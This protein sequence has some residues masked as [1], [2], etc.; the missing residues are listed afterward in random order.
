MG[1]RNFSTT[2]VPLPRKGLTK[3]TNFV[4]ERPRFRQAFT[5]LELQA[6]IHTPSESGLPPPMTRRQRKALAKKAKVAVK[7]QEDT[8]DSAAI[9]ATPDGE[10]L[11]QGGGGERGGEGGV[12]EGSLQDGHWGYGDQGVL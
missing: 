6:R 5:H 12:G 10:G 9:Y 7:N 4:N 3:I 8:V 2:C 11:A 1:K